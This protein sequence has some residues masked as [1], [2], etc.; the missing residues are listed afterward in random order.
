VTDRILNHV[1]TSFGDVA[2]SDQGD[3]SPALFV[4]GIFLNGYLW[5]HV[6]D[7]VADLRRCIAVDI[8]GHGET[9][10]PADADM[11]FDAH[12]AMLEAVC[13]G[14]GLDQV[15]LVAND[16]GGGIAQIFAAR[17]PQRIRTLTLTNCDVHDNYPPPALAPILA[18]VREGRLGAIGQGMLGNLAVAQATLSVG[19]EHPDRLTEDMVRTYLEPLFR[20]PEATRLFER[21]FERMDNGQ[22]VRI[23]PMLRA[24]DV[25]ALI[26]W[27][28]GD[29][30]FD[31][32][33]AHWLAETL[34]GARPP[35]ILDGA[36]LF[37][38]EERAPEL[39]APLRDFWL[40]A[41]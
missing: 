19:Y 40:G 32:T 14:L 39:I 3:G 30:F 20:T 4:H 6:I 16:S 13:D 27:G 26:V 35:V 38:P 2:Y 7:G 21:M 1:S 41:A 12:A 33:W 11:S 17:H 24:L 31:V 10:T 28:T 25:P 37:F 36:K 29:I 34:P 22:T 8:L 5:R 15:D 9:R 23:E 18:A